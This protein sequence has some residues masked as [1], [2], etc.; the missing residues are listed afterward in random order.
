[1]ENCVRFETFKNKITLWTINYLRL[2]R[3]ALLAV[4]LTKV[5]INF[6]L[7]QAVKAQKGSRG[8]ALLFL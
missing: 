3:A 4:V 8:I 5:K 2:Q 1:M 6:N 7:K